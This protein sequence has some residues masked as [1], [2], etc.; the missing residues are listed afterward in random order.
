VTSAPS[1]L[2]VWLFVLLGVAAAVVGL[3]PWLAT[4]MRLSL[5]NLWAFE[6]MPEAMPLALLPFSQYALTSIVGLIVTG[7]AIAGL[8]ARALRRRMPRRGFAGL[9]VGVLGVQL[10]AVAQTALVVQSGLQRRFESTV[11][12]LALIALALFSI[13]VGVL[14]LWLIARAPRAGALIGFAFGAIAVGFWASTLLAPFLGVGT[15]D[16]GW[17]LD[18][19][20]WVPAV[21]IGAAIAWCG[22]GTVG[23]VVAAIASLVV[24]WLAPALA[25][26]VSSA[27][28]TRVLATRPAEMLDYGVG[29]FSAA[30]TIPELV[31]PPIIVAIVVAGLGLALH[32]G[33][34]SARVGRSREGT[35]GGGG[36]GTA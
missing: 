9:L 14:L 21:L 16:V 6:T 19:L 32:A 31:L 1:L 33:I 30:S 36:G 26:A 22:V 27:V 28:G 2:S 23:R 3:L 17:L 7:S 24:L 12:L 25:T 11:Y 5:Q 20:R 18:W 34:S 29:V 10:I 13:A 35:G 8:L 4:G 15:V